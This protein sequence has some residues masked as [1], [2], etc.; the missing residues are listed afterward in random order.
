MAAPQPPR[1]WRGTAPLPAPSS[2]ASPS[3]TLSSEG[4][5]ER[6]RHRLGLSLGGGSMLSGQGLVGSAQRC[7]GICA[8][9]GGLF[10]PWLFRGKHTQDG[11]RAPR[12]LGCL[13]FSDTRS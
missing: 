9:P 12:M 10:V 4:L 13:G 11:A 7:H 3:H 5:E 2:R 1:P 6:L 8:A